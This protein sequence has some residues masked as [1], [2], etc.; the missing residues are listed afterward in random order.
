[1]I[2]KAFGSFYFIFLVC[3]E[4]PMANTYPWL[5]RK[6]KKDS[7]FVEKGG[8]LVGWARAEEDWLSSSWVTLFCFFRVIGKQFSWRRSLKSGKNSL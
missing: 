4:N 1:M 5:K 3:F 8:G 2:L 7:Y 6:E